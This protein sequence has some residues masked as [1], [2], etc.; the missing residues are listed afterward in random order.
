MV[1]WI[2]VPSHVEGLLAAVAAATVAAGALIGLLAWRR[3]RGALLGCPAFWIG[4]FS[5]PLIL[6]LWRLYNAIEDRFGLD[7]LVALG[8]NAAIFLSVGAALG[9]WLRLGGRKEKD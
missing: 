3:G 1:N 8:L 2:L 5:G 4:A 6:A 7:S 9:L